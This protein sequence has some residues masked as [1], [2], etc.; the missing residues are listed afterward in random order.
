MTKQNFYLKS[1]ICGCFYNIHFYVL[2]CPLNQIDALY[3]A[4][5]SESFVFL[6][7]IHGYLVLED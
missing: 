2:N 4:R 5:R 7:W 6:I 3:Q 1:D